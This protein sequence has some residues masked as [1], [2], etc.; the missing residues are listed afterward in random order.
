MR[1]SQMFL[2]TLKEIPN[3][4]EA[5]S[6]ILMIRSGLVRKLT[7]GVY[8]YL[9]LGLKVLQKVENIIREEMNRKGAQEVLLPAIQPVELWGKS[10][11]LKTLGEDMVKFTDRHKKINVLGPTHEE[12]VT[13]LVKNEVSSYRQLPL[14]LYQIQTKFRD[15]ARPR[16]GVIRSREFIM[17][18]AYSFDA[19]SEG[20]NFSYQKM[21]DAYCQI[22]SR[23]GLKFIPVEADTG[24]MGGDVSHEFM[25]LAEN[26]EDKIV[27]CSQCGYAVSFARAE[28]VEPKGNNKPADLKKLSEVKT[29]KVTSV[30]AVADFFKI[31]PDKLIKTM[32]Y[33]SDA[34]PIAVLVRGDHEI[35][36]SKLKKVLKD[37]SL[38]L[39]DEKLIEKITKG[40]L[41]FSGP[42]GLSGI[43]IIADYA[44][45]NERDNVV[46]A[47]KADAHLINANS[48]RDFKVDLWAD[49]RNITDRDF[50]P[51]CA[52]QIKIQPAIEIGHVFKLGTKYTTSFNAAYLDAEGRSSE[53]LMGCYGIGVNRII[54]ASIEQN[55]DENGIIWPKHISP[56]DVLILPLNPDHTA[57][58]DTAV[59]I[60]EQLKERNI[61]AL[62]DDRNVR[63]GIK[64]K[65]AD[66]I[67]IP[68]QIIIGEKKLGQ[69]KIEIKV[70][71]TN[72][73]MEIA[74]SESVNKITEL[75]GE[76]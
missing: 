45:K 63:A 6:H 55:H 29:P 42:V 35:N 73:R 43:E 66:L 47:N 11:R 50:C 74:A 20:L 59:K 4:A 24:V 1:W 38:K 54:A 40:P 18:D 41:G 72:E 36:E 60:Y 49:L 58:Q 27:V 62:L 67:G 12:V 15:E 57:S 51:K 21:Y 61:E 64:F 10:G 53:I 32:I 56:F 46:G 37:S 5:V 31:K 3:E 76:V 44:L 22:F 26:G 25:V 33:E 69:G 68:I 30:E 23:C 71:S 28:C 13:L 75:V 70:R 65:D 52:R 39:G 19:T 17:K 34:K 8:S 14:I 16:F 2:P 7:A 9:P 48:G